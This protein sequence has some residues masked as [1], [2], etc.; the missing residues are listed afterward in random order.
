M[1]EQQL[2]HC[3]AAVAGSIHEARQSFVGPILSGNRA[4]V[5]AI[6][7]QMAERDDLRERSTMACAII[8][9]VRQEA[10]GGG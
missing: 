3:L 8:C 7:D 9:S 2:H 4:S 5:E 1:L 10:K 6:R